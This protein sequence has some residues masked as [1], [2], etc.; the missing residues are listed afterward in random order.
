MQLLALIICAFFLPALCSLQKD[1]ADFAPVSFVDTAESAEDATNNSIT[2]RPLLT[3]QVGASKL[4]EQIRLKRKAGKQ[5]NRVKGSAKSSN[6]GET[7]EAPK[8]TDEED[9]Y[10][11]KY[12]TKFGKLIFYD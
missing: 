10:H 2:L 7:T 3:N 4:K 8:P 1:E 9:A 12:E 5:R 11:V 6:G